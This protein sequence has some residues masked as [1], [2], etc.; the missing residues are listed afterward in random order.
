MMI[1]SKAGD[2]LYTSAILEEIAAMVFDASKRL[3][4]TEIFLFNRTVWPQLYSPE[5]AR[6]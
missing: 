5:A 2:W 3:N 1:P 4:I 6:T